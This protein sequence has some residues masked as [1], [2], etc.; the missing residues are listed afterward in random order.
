[1]LTLLSAALTQRIS[2]KYQI[3]LESN[4]ILERTEHSR[5]GCAVVKVCKVLRLRRRARSD[6]AND[7]WRTRYCF[8]VAVAFSLLFF[9]FLSSMLCDDVAASTV[10]IALL[11]STTHLLV[12]ARERFWTSAHFGLA[13]LHQF[14]FGTSAARCVVLV[15][16]LFCLFVCLNAIV[17]L[18]ML[19]ILH[20]SGAFYAHVEAS[21]TTAARRAIDI[22]KQSSPTFQLK[23]TDV[24]FQRDD[25]FACC[26]GHC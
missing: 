14:L 17:V 1:M 15:L 5:I 18:D 20:N 16:A 12:D 24:C 2:N 9:F 21:L 3:H 6:S 4:R 25:M 8:C 7:G 22:A 10:T 23:V 11:S 13:G 19:Y 26:G